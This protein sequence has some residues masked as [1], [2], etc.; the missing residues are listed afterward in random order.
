[1]YIEK[2]FLEDEEDIVA[3]IMDGFKITYLDLYTNYYDT[4]KDYEYYH[5]ENIVMAEVLRDVEETLR[6]LIKR[7]ST[8]NTLYGYLLREAFL[9]YEEDYDIRAVFKMLIQYGTEEGGSFYGTFK[10]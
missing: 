8:Y 9:Q 4:E 2:I 3:L 1:M 7:E 6:Y 5:D 10:G